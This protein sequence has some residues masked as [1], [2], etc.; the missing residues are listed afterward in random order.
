MTTGTNDAVYH[1][2]PNPQLM[3]LLDCFASS[4]QLAHVFNETMP[5]RES[6]F[7]MGYMK[8]LPNLLKQETMSVN[9]YLTFLVKIF[10]DSDSKRDSEREATE[11]RLIP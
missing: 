7:K 9:V 10:V 3:Q 5:L 6:L 11:Q 2:L 4:Y 8:Q 1:A